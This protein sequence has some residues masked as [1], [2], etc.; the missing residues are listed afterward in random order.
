MEVSELRRIYLGLNP[1]D[2]KWLRAALKARYNLDEPIPGVDSSNVEDR[3]KGKAPIGHPRIE[4]DECDGSDDFDGSCEYDQDR[5]LETRQKPYFDDRGSLVVPFSS[6]LRF[7]YW[8]GG[9]SLTDTLR[10]IENGLK[11]KRSRE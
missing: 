9:Q 6:P 4:C 8:N 7:H 10:E 5:T 3:M 2:H 11:G 1:I